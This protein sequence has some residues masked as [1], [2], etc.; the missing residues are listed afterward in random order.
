MAISSIFQF[1]LKAYCN[2]HKATA[3]SKSLGVETNLL[4]FLQFTDFN[5]EHVILVT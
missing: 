2:D 1:H 5:Q 3:I 4:L